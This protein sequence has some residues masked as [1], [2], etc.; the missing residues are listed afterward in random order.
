[1]AD[2]KELII[3]IGMDRSK[4]TEESRRFREDQR[5]LSREVLSDADAEERAKVAMNRDT[6]GRFVAGAARARRAGDEAGRSF[7][8]MGRDAASAFDG[9]IQRASQFAGSL[10]SIVVGA[11]AVGVVRRA[12]GEMVGVMEAA[13]AEAR[14]QVDSLLS[15][16]EAMREIS[17][18]TGS[19]EGPTDAELQKLLNVRTA[20]GLSQGEAQKMLLEF[21][22]AGNV[23]KGQNI[24]DKEY[25]RFKPL[26]AKFAAT[27]GGGEEGAGTYG[28][29]GGL[30]LG[31]RHYDKAED[32]LAAE[33][34]FNRILSTGVGDNPT[35]IKQGAKVA[36]AYISENG[37]GIVKDERE[38]AAITATASRIN[39]EEAA[40][41]MKS[42]TRV[43]RGFDEKWKPL[44]KKA[45]ITEK[46]TY[47]EAFNKLS[48]HLEGIEKSGRAVDAYMAEQGVDQHGAVNVLSMYRYRG[49]LNNLM[50]SEGNTRMTGEQAQAQ[51][52]AKYRGDVSLRTKVEQAKLDEAKHHNAM[53]LQ[54]ARPIELEAERRLT[55]EGM[56]EDSAAGRLEDEKIGREATLAGFIPTG[57]MTSE[58]VGHRIRRER[59]MNRIVREKGLT[60]PGRPEESKQEGHYSPEYL[61]WFNSGQDTAAYSAVGSEMEMAAKVTPPPGPL[62]GR[63]PNGMDLGPAGIVPPASP[64]LPDVPAS[65]PLGDPRMMGFSP[66]PSSW[67]GFD[68]APAAMQPPGAK[69]DPAMDENNRRL[70]EISRKLDGRPQA[71]AP[72]PARSGPPATLG[73]PR[74][75]TR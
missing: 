20:S 24:S 2:D 19:K 50:N 32:V 14:K 28:K 4:A 9:A 54:H 21:E 74:G 13:N 23:A 62:R 22:G 60:V 29:L 65:L 53:Q 47:S 11:A 59:E 61:A 71:A 7:L 34:Q 55:R 27:A 49:T 73:A 36:G 33:T 68:A 45:G 5:K 72:A 37:H 58:Q 12:M 17:M 56:G 16:K 42:T 40:E 31:L 30:L 26:L 57:G 25:E 48:T 75:Q 69:P 38:L 6:N 18:I 43:L 41:V 39:P 3:K 66:M 46:D 67:V 1:M 64:A 35:L 15:A 51:L 44:L 70:G 10:Q 63:R 8:K 52:D